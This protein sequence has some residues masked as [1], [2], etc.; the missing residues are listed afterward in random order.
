M[1]LSST[2]LL[3]TLCFGDHVGLGQ[4]REREKDLMGKKKNVVE[5]QYFPFF[6]FYI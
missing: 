5:R 2:A 4:Q 3:K 1:N 6:A